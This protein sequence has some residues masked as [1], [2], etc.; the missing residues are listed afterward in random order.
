ME[1]RGVHKDDLP[2]PLGED[3]PKAL[4]GGLGAGAYGGHLDAQ[5][6][7]EEGGLAHV[8]LAH[9]GHESGIGFLFHG[10]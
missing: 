7:V 9:D 10:G 3:A 6:V 8:G 1:A 2:V 5:Q 4:P